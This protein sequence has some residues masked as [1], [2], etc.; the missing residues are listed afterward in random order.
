MLRRLC[1]NRGA[2]GND[3][4]EDEMSTT[5]RS[6][7]IAEIDAVLRPTLVAAYLDRAIA[8][9]HPANVA[10]R[11]ASIDLGYDQ[12]VAPIHRVQAVCIAARRAALDSITDLEER[13]RL[14]RRVWQLVD[15]ALL[16]GAER[17]LADVRSLVSGLNAGAGA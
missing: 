12:I 14:D 8:A 11:E 2:A 9:L 15:E 1:G 5:N 17:N 6:F 7:G 4:A 10:A 13:E 3:P 16:V